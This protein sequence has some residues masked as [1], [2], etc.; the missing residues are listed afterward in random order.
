MGE[1][2]DHTAGGFRVE[3]AKA[4]TTVMGQAKLTQL[5]RGRA[6]WHAKR[7]MS[8][9]AIKFIGRWAS[10]VIEAYVENAVE[11]QAC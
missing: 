7:G 11:G 5:M 6:Q 4:L 1:F 3:Y 10:D 8:L 9:W 2:V